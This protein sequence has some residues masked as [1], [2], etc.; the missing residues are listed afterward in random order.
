MPAN[1]EFMARVPNPVTPQPTLSSGTPPPTLCRRL[2]SDASNLR[3]RHNTRVGGRGAWL[4][5]APQGP[6]GPRIIQVG[7]RQEDG[8]PPPCRPRT[9]ASRGSTPFRSVSWSTPHSPPCFPRCPF[10]TSISS[11]IAYVLGWGGG[12]VSAGIDIYGTSS[13]CSLKVSL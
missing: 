10:T 8:A 4:V 3:F 7:G 11:T 1:A 12:A 13:C 6:V 2:I 9:A 5:W